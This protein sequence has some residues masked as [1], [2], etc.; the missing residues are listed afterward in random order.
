VAATRVRD[1]G[2]KLFGNADI[3]PDVLLASTCPP[4][5]HCAVEIDG[6]SYWDGGFSANP[7]VAGLMRAAEGDVLVVQV[8]PSRDSYIPITSA[9]IDRRRDQITANSALN[10]EI[11]A[12]EWMRRDAASG[13]RIFR[14]AAEDE[15]DGLAQRS[16]VDLGANF[17]KLLH[18][19]GR[20]AADRWL[21]QSPGTAAAGARQHEKSASAAKPAL[22]AELV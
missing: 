7:P 16:A 11:V 20:N 14:I 18:R 15:I 2:L 8:T 21:R 22:E 10:A 17:V 5:V 12:L 3:T 4:L 6:E 1:G 9:A 19:S 13:P